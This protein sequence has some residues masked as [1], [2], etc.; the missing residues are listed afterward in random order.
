MGVG[1]GFL[2]A[3]AILLT[4]I[5]LFDKKHPVVW[6]PDPSLSA[7]AAYIV[8]GTALTALLIAIV[9]LS[10]YI[11]AILVKRSTWRDLGRAILAAAIASAMIFGG[12]QLSLSAFYWPWARAS[13]LATIT[14]APEKWRIVI[15]ARLLAAHGGSAT[16][17]ALED[18]AREAGV[19][20]RSAA[21][22]GLAASG[23]KKALAALAALGGELAPASSWTERMDEEIE[24]DEETVVSTRDDVLWLINALTEEEYASLDDFAARA[25]DDMAKLTWD[26]QRGVYVE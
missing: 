14:G 2:T 7:T 24:I 10:T 23:D 15:C 11:I 6:P 19:A 18:A 8:I 5:F 16:T 17:A 25:D 4:S 22:F 12:V 21:L 3:A 9:W 20:G 13:A 26:A 1:V